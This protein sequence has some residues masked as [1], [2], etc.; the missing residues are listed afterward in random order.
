MTKPGAV[1][2]LILAPILCCQP[3]E[4]AG[5]RILAF[6]N[7]T[8][9]DAT[10][11]PPQP[12]MTLVVVGSRI[13]ALDKTTSVEL[14]PDA[15]LVDATGKFVIPGL[16]NMH[17]HTLQSMASDG[18]SVDVH[19]TF[20]PLFVANGITGVR[21][22]NGD[23]AILKRVRQSISVGELLGPTIVAAGP[24]VDGVSWP[25]GSIAV[26]SEDDGRRAVRLLEERGAD[27]VKVGSLVPREAYFSIADEAKRRNLPVAGHVPFSV[28]AAEASDAGQRSIEHFDGVLIACSRAERVLREEIRE[29]IE[30]GDG[31]FS[32]VWL[33]RVRAEAK[34]LDTCEQKL[35]SQLTSLFANNRTWQVPTLTLKRATAFIDDEDFTDDPRVEYIPDFLTDTWGEDNPLT[36][37]YTSKDFENEKRVFA[38]QLELVG[39]MHEAGV[40][41]MAGTDAIDPF[42]FPGF[43]LHDELALF[44]QAGLTPMEALQTATRNPAQYLGMS[45]SVGTVG[46]GTLADL[47][48]LDG[49]PLEDIRNTQKI[50]AVV[51][52]GRLLQ[53]EALEELLA[54]QRAA[55]SES[56]A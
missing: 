29:A 14:P 4:Q 56:G 37:D 28:T 42:I 46:V 3:N 18:E 16:W 15:L 30:T 47:V 49:N 11:S 19:E 10:G 33:A 6:T 40:M 26:Q 2:L 50:W 7:V 51:L 55:A 9:I 20:F 5:D 23:L 8:V 25:F 48:L 41:F 38:K 27:F 34:A 52:Q 43:S 39:E 31:G 54:S 45:D 17:V 35:A 24:I 22:M 13:T 32:V 36:G 12:G 44:V 21:D 53:K 1:M